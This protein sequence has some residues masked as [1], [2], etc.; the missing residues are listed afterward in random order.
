MMQRLLTL[1]PDHEPLWVRL[2][3]QPMGDHGTAY[4]GGQCATRQAHPTWKRAYSSG[5]PGTRQYG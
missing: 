3:V 5:P 1:G 2:C 4:R